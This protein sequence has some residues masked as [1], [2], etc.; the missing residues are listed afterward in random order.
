MHASYK[1]T[2]PNNICEDKITTKRRWNSDMPLENIF[3]VEIVDG[4]KRFKD[5]N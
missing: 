5:G 4:I 3:L 1:L 2:T